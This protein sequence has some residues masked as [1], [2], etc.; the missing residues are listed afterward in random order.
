MAAILGGTGECGKSLLTNMFKSGAL[1][2]LHLVGRRSQLQNLP[3]QKPD[4]ISL[5][6]SIV[7]FEQLCDNPTSA[8]FSGDSNPFKHEIPE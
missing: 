6:E 7:D 2:N 5:T 3:F 4:S 8:N 1:A